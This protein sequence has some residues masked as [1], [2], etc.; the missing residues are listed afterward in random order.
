MNF[1]LIW[2]V[3][4]TAPNSINNK[5]IKKQHYQKCFIDFILSPM[6]GFWPTKGVIFKNEWMDHNIMYDESE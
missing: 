5:N 1:T 2:H 4:K 3:F 6:I